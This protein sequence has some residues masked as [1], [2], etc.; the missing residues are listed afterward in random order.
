LKDRRPIAVERVLDF[1]D[2]IAVA[3]QAFGGDGPREMAIALL[4]AGRQV[5]PLLLGIPGYRRL[6]QTAVVV[7][8]VAASPSVGADHIVNF[9]LPRRDDAALRNIGQALISLQPRDRNGITRAS[10]PK[11]GAIVLFN[12]DVRDRGAVG[13]LAPGRRPTPARTT[14]R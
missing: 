5:P 1:Q 3:E 9:F 10:E 14:A 12:E 4:I 13:A 2:T 7:D 11:W 6:K 8:Q